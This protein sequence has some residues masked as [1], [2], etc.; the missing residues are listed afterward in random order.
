M[1]EMSN[2]KA[3]ILVVDDTRANLRLLTGMLAEQ[4]YIVRP[5]PNG[6]LALSAVQAEPP[7]LILL[8]I[9]MPQMSGYEV[10]EHL[11]ADQ[12][13]RSIPV[14]FISAKNEIPDKIKAFS[15]GGVD[16][17]TK[18]FQAEEVLARIETHLTLRNLQKSLQEK[19]ALLRQ[20]IIE[21]KHAE[22][23]LRKSQE[24]LEYAQQI[25]KIGNW[26][27]DVATSKIKWSREMYRIHGIDS[28]TFDYDP[29]AI[30]EKFVHPEDKGMLLRTRKTLLSTDGR[31]CTEY[32]IV[33]PDG[34]IRT[35]WGEDEVIFSE[36]GEPLRMVGVVQDITERKDMEQEIV[37]AK[38]AA[39]Y[40]N[41]AKSE[42]L[43]NISHEIR[44][45]MNAILGFT[46][47]LLSKIRNSRYNNYLSS[48]YSSGKALL[49][50]IDDILDL[51]K[52]EAGK[53]EIQPEPADIKVL[54]NEIRLL[55]QQKYQNKEIEFKLNTGKH[56]PGV[57]IDVVRIRQILINLI[58]NAL[59]FTSR[60]YVRL[61]VY[62]EPS[63]MLKSPD[64][65]ERVNVI[66]EVEDTGIG[67]PSD[68]QEIIFENFRQ[69]SGQ[70]TRKYGGTGLGLAIT[71]KLVEIMNGQISLQSKVDQGSIFRVVVPDI[72]VVKES[73]LP[74]NSCESQDVCTEFEPALIMV[75]DEID[76]NREIVKGLLE[77]TN[78]EITEADSDETALNLLTVQK[79]D[80]ILMDLIMPEKSGYEV[81]QLIKEMDDCKHI[82]VIALTAS[83]MKDT[84]EKIK[85][86]FDGYLRKPVN[87]NQLIS[88][89]KKF[90]PFRTRKTNLKNSSKSF[91][92]GEEHEI[93]SEEAKNRLPELVKTFDNKITPRWEE[94]SEAFFIDDVAEFASELNSVAQEYNIRFLADYS[95]NL[96]ENAQSNNIDEIEKIMEKFPEVA[97]MVRKL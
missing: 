90:L 43:A 13:T 26:E 33:R 75:V 53:L 73:E 62:T 92:V 46:E 23:A 32:R 69:Q 30:F 44:T 1:T 93:I 59:K 27:F 94:I 70:K 58:G 36:T 34:K 24:S 87:R 63:K 56:L 3:N 20:E 66:F 4:D 84:E 83:G 80:L 22:E 81:A 17:I 85:E 88:E 35:L 60:G 42:F 71:K 40:A 64:D 11:K 31:I 7:D 8:D 9:M 47:I 5:V 48:I 96:Y 55:F 29:G 65:Q 21:R 16:Y 39:E 28:G 86:S 18:P 67:I 74:D 79:P 52:V 51:S 45:P 49:S 78:F 14:I 61:S 2:T 72:E 54:L 91:S 77:S 97:D 89:L 50:L 68:Q 57:V 15:L 12:Q 95:K 10:C 82:P 6:A 38:E 41:R 37:K 76:D 25:A 19:N